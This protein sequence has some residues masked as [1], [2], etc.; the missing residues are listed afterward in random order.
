MLFRSF[1]PTVFS[2]GFFRRF[3]FFTYFIFLVFPNFSNMLFSTE[4]LNNSLARLSFIFNIFSKSILVISLFFST[5]SI[6]CFI[7]ISKFFL[8][9]RIKLFLQDNLLFSFFPPRYIFNCS[10]I[11][12]NFQLLFMFYVVK[13]SF[14]FYILELFCH[15]PYLIFPETT[16]SEERRVGKECRSRWSPY[17]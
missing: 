12:Y 11:F 6:I 10:I 2:D 8:F 1:F 15:L 7:C 9:S 17:H 5:N 13:P 4:Y 3:Y 14:I 16:R